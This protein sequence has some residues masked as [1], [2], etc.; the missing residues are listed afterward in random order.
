M[1]TYESVQSENMEL[2]LEIVTLK[3][4]LSDIYKQIGPSSSEYITLSIKLQSLMHQ[5]FDE[6][7][8]DLLN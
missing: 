4:K 7:T 8:A 6:K 3:T 5:Y 2:L 1:K